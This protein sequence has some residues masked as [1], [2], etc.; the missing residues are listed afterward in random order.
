MTAI[1]SR[2]AQAVITGAAKACNTY[3]AITSH[4]A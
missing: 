4:V 2:V 3:Y 1:T